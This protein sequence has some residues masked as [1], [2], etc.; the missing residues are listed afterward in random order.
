MISKFN[1]RQQ[2]KWNRSNGKYRFLFLRA[3]TAIFKTRPLYSLV[4][5]RN[6]VDPL[7]KKPPQ[8]SNNYKAASIYDFTYFLL[9]KHQE[10]CGRYVKLGRKRN[11]RIR[12]KYWPFVVR[13]LT[14]STQELFRALR[15]WVVIEWGSVFA[16]SKS[17]SFS[18]IQP[19]IGQNNLADVSSGGSSYTISHSHGYCVSISSNVQLKMKLIKLNLFNI[20]RSCV[21]AQLLLQLILLFLYFLCCQW[22][23]LLFQQL[24]AYA[25]R[26][27]SNR[28]NICR[29]RN[30]TL[31]H[32][33]SGAALYLDWFGGVFNLF[34]FIFFFF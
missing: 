25:Q 6:A 13:R 33:C 32:G 17:L 16:S 19:V 14:S 9:I 15:R 8:H 22:R 12:S 34:L 23:Y 31:M 29:A 30:S 11:T 26:A 7:S 3:M 2:R 27:S 21:S 10:A 18:N 4:Q 20:T 1:I 5:A 28:T 24:R